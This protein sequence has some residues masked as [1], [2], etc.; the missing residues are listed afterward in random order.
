MC[1]TEKSPGASLIH[2]GVGFHPMGGGDIPSI[3]FLLNAT[4]GRN[5]LS[6][7]YLL[8]KFRRWYGM[9]IISKPRV[10]FNLK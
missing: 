10:V 8:S 2:D 1:L 5:G 7:G 4:E 9:P 6:F 3:P